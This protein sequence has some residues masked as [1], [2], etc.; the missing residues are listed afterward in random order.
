[1]YDGL[2]VSRL[3]THN[4]TKLLKIDAF[5]KVSIER[6]D[7]GLE[8]VVVN[9]PTA[10][11]AATAAAGIGSTT[12][13]TGMNFP[14]DFLQIFNG[15]DPL[16]VHVE[17]AER[18][19][20]VRH[21]GTATTAGSADHI[22]F[23]GQYVQN[24]LDIDLVGV[25]AAADVFVVI[26][27]RY[28]GRDLLP[29]STPPPFSGSREFGHDIIPRHPMAHGAEERREGVGRDG[30]RPIVVEHVELCSNLGLVG[31]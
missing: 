8:Q 24:Q 9:R 18:I 4:T 10:T 29:P 19:L 12:S 11:A 28:H 2:N 15:D 1:M 13:S 22:S 14:C 27:I 31:A 7:H 20:Q 26:V 6:F 17:Q 3:S 16:V 21:F 25:A 5:S 30:T 23:L